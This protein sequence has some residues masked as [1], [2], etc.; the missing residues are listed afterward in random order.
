[1]VTSVRSA[2]SGVGA[3]LALTVL[4]AS[5]AA[6][7]PSLA[8]K[9]DQPQEI[10]AA[11]QA[12]RIGGEFIKADDGTTALGLGKDFGPAIPAA[13]FFAETGTIAFSVRYVEPE[14]AN[15]LRNRHLVTLRLEGRGFL[16]FYFIQTDRRLQMAYKQMPESI[17][18]VTPAPLQ[19]GQ[20]Y[21]AAATWDGT[22]VCFYLDGKLVGEMK[23][24]FPASYPPY[25]RLNL[26]PYKDGWQVAKPW[27][28]NDVSIRDLKVWK[29]AL[30]P[31]EIAADAGVEA[32]A[33]ETRFPTLLAVP[34]VAAPSVDGK[35]DEPAWQAAASF[36]S[37]LDMTKPAAS[38]AYPD[39]R[40][41]LLHDGQALY[42]GFETLFPTGARLIPGQK[43]EGAEPEVWTDESFE[44]YLDVEGRLY[45][46]AGNAAGGYCESLNNGTDFNGRWE[47]ASS[48][49]FRI[50]NRWHW[51]GELRLPFETIGLSQPVG[52]EL[53]INFCRTWRCFDTIGLTSLQAATSNY[54]DRTRFVTVRLAGTADAGRSAGSS[55]PSFGTFTQTVTLN[56]ARGGEFV[57]TI[58]AL[59]AA[60]DGAAL[61]EKRVSLAPGGRTELPI[62]A[63][64]SAAS[65]RF[66]LFQL[67]AP[68]GE[69]LLR[70]LVPFRLSEDY[71]DVTPVF[72]SGRILLKPRYAMLK[73]QDPTLVPAVRVLGPDRQV[74]HEEPLS[75]DDPLSLPFDRAAPAGTYQAEVVSGHGDA[76]KVLTSKMFQYTA[77]AP[78]EAMPPVDTVPAPFTPL[79]VSR[80]A[81]RLEVDVW[82][83]RYGFEG[84]LLPVSIQTQ[85]KELL[86][87]PVQ[88][89]I[90][91]V[92]LRP[93]G[94]A[95]KSES[96]LRL[97]FTSRSTA[98]G[99]TATQDAWLEYDG[100]FF[101]RVT[102]QATRDLGAL[103]LALP[104][105]APAA[106]FAH[107]TA[108]GFGGGGRQNLWLD[109]DQQLPFY[110]S[111]WI[112]N[113][114]RGLAWFAESA[115]GWQTRDPR[116]LK[117]VRDGD[118][119]R[120]QVTFADALPAGTALTV[121]F[122]LLATP[123]R[124]LPPEYPL[125]LFSDCFS[126]HLNRPA[127]RRPVIT[128]GEASWEG[129]GFFDLPIGVENPPVWQWLQ[130]H[131]QR[132][133]ANRGIL[134]PYTA[135]MMVPEEYPEAASRIA[136][137]QLSPASHL[138]YTRDGQKRTWYWTCAASDAGNFFAWK[139]DQLLDRVPLRG[140]YLDFGAASRCSNALHGCHD[141]FPLL[142]QRRLY[143]RLAASFVRHGVKDYA[144]VV[145]NSESVQWPTFTH[146]THFFN[147]EGLRQM[148][149]TTFHG[150]KDLQDTY[151]RLDFAMEH[152]SLPF[153]ITSSVYVPTDPLLKQF[154]GGVEDQ[155][156]Y[157]FRMTKAALAGT[158]VH[159]TIASP[160][161]MHYGWYDK[162]VR[163]YEAFDVPAAEFLPY[164]RNQAMVRVTQGKDIY[165][166]LYRAPDR[167]EVLAVIS[168]L[169]K[170]HADQEVA[171][172][173]D[174]AALGVAG[175]ERAEE[176]LTA[177]DP[178]YERLYAE[179]NRV[180][181]P[182]KL[183][184]FGIENV[185]F[186]GTALT[187]KLAFHSVAIVKFTGRR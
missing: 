98:A 25:A 57:Y 131:F 142:A 119:T 178:E 43:R 130:E 144:I 162:I 150:G 163:I 100:V 58:G 111:V 48:L 46:F 160:S 145:H 110:P 36:V 173:L 33:A 9:L 126:V 32:P 49:S 79:Q 104:L 67:Q 152:S 64:I 38:L 63:A 124:P 102:V 97:A 103:T 16:G 53:K 91:G 154:G 34:Q 153:G 169:S 47:Y 94:W 116:P 71:L 26:G 92:P 117:I 20:A 109:R 151:T 72:G 69:L 138:N 170:E 143:Q 95:V 73:S 37:L 139:F 120:L 42:L 31:V 28:A 171:V 13:P 134:T 135:A 181:M 122:G 30:G 70:Q 146:V 6:P 141:G 118:T 184:D 85:G 2:V 123:V 14:P 86:S 90:G 147:G 186:D 99:Y 167:P 125:D 83:R 182:I 156:L 157:R 175:W 107:A 105:P 59:N 8:L 3:L 89:A 112:G 39:N 55:D 23:Q 4:A 21:R 174:P 149:S 177:P 183:G 66:L 80:R 114:E 12:V 10:V 51:Q 54:G 27:E 136:E 68:G 176:L 60:G 180:R 81:P 61:V 148:S 24:G 22:T 165:V 35:L 19:A 11:G 161:R 115:S 41:L 76:L 108:A 172:V 5:H 101:N 77:S 1:M 17:R 168:H 84:S 166:S 40:P 52:R 187:L 15:S 56:S 133:E 137:W 113:E 87:A 93:D 129:A 7:P 50:D 96:P 65:A 164:W 62:V 44:F 140:L 82:G 45:R 88:L 158:L 159:N 127:P 78:W 185:R 106:A 18:L 74:L 155:E 132:F 128:C 179:K 75:G 29:Q 121:E